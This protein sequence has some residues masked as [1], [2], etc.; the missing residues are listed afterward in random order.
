MLKGAVW[1]NEDTLSYK[2]EKCRPFKVHEKAFLDSSEHFP[3]VHKKAFLG[4]SEDR[5]RMFWV[6]YN[7]IGVP[8]GAAKIQKLQ[9]WKVLRQKPIESQSEDSRA[10][11]RQSCLPPDIM[12]SSHKKLQVAISSRKLRKTTNC[13]IW[14]S[15]ATLYIFPL[16][17]VDLCF[18]PWLFSTCS[19]W[20]LGNQLLK[21]VTDHKIAC[22]ALVIFL[23]VEP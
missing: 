5:P 3:K 17:Q 9:E 13:F 12:Y 23:N 21:E 20:V 18:S 7:N 11:L 2:K 16:T 14:P 22:I 8:D 6:C 4:P 10:W 15:L 19:D 1:E